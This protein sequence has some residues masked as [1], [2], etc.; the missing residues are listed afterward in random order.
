VGWFNSPQWDNEDL[1]KKIAAKRDDLHKL[2]ERLEVRATDL[3]DED[4]HIRSI[5][6]NTALR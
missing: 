6:I 5:A 4:L 1:R 2:Q 3:S